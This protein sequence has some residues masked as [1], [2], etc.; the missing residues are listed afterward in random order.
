MPTLEAND[1]FS[2]VVKQPLSDAQLSAARREYRMLK[3]LVVAA[4]WLACA[5]SLSLNIADPDLWGHVHYGGELLAAGELPLTATHTYTA[6]GYRWVNH[7]TLA[8]V[9]FAGVYTWFGDQGLL[10]L[11]LLLGLATLVGMAWIARRQGVGPLATA[12]FLLLIA[13]NLTPFFTVRPQV[14]SFACCGLMLLLIELAFTGWRSWLR[15]SS[16]A[17]EQASE[18]VLPWS[19]QRLAW[20]LG[21][22]P[23]MVLWVNS[24][25][26]FVAGLCIL[27]AVLGGRAIEAVYFRRGQALAAM[28]ALMGIAVLAVTATLANPYGTGLHGWIWQ[29]L[30]QPRPE[31]TEW[32]RLRP[33]SAV[34]WPFV[35]LATVTLVSLLFTRLKRDW[36]QIA[37]LA[38]TAWQACVHMRHV[39]FFAILAGFWIAPH[40]K[41]ALLRSRPD[42]SSFPVQQLGLWVRWSLAGV[43]LAAIGLQSFAL[44]NR[45]SALP[46]YRSMYPVDALQWMTFKGIDGKL[47]CSY[48]WA[49]YA[50]FALSPDTQVAFDGRFR[51]C[52]PQ[53]V[54]DLSFDFLL[55]DNQGRRYR[56]PATGPIDPTAILDRNDPDLVLV[57]RNYDHSVQVMEDESRESDPEWALLYQDGI[58]QLW[59]RRS[60]YDDPHSGRYIAPN[61]RL[62][63]NRVHRNAVVW[64]AAPVQPVARMLAEPNLSDHNAENL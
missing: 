39:A 4:L 22:V 37:L 34:F 16:A 59:G 63:T 27:L 44:A 20:L 58:A 32:T 29:S 61:Q 48:N 30:A 36:V 19:I 21:L 50:I 49:Q 6:E 57:D 31:I 43:L 23:L 41:S 54:V 64:P 14:F 47:V 24:H 46:V 56:H 12:I 8:E 3:R 51:T 62:V 9:T 18:A 52:Y 17:S 45:L 25:G 40:L 1:G 26:G 2:S 42:T 13:N 35:A 5:L 38:V 53:Q 11:K 10:S 7:E 60:T 15:D 28:F 33:A 55:G